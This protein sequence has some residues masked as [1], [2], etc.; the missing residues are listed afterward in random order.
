MSNMARKGRR[1]PL[2]SNMIPEDGWNETI[3]DPAAV[4]V[5][6]IHQNNQYVMSTIERVVAQHHLIMPKI[7][8]FDDGVNLQ[9]RSHGEAKRFREIIS[10]LP[11]LQMSAD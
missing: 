7:E 3:N 2:L 9:F 5:E 1:R 4:F 10:S 8:F 6:L 11:R